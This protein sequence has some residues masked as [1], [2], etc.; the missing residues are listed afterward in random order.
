VG[1]EVPSAWHDGALSGLRRPHAGAEDRRAPGPSACRSAACTSASDGCARPC[2]WTPS[3][4]RPRRASRSPSTPSRSTRS[5]SPSASW[6]PS[7]DGNG[8]GAGPQVDV[9]GEAAV[10]HGAAPAHHRGRG[11]EHRRASTAVEHGAENPR[12][13]ALLRLKATAARPRRSARLD[14]EPSGTIPA[15]GEAPE[16][17]APRKSAS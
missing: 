6:P 7:C 5:A 13:P 4:Q 12:R 10:S 17:R 1:N 8:P 14:H 9:A 3:P 16:T 15:P 11:R 2:A